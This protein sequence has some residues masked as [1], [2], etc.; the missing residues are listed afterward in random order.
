MRDLFGN[1]IKQETDEKPVKV[2]NLSPFDYLNSINMNKDNLMRDEYGINE[3]N[4]KTYNSWLVNKGLSY[5]IDTLEHS[6]NM[7]LY[8]MHLDN[9]MKY[10]YLLYSVRK[11][12]RFSKWHKAINNETID[13]IMNYY[14]ISY[15]KA[16]DFIKILTK[17]QIDQIKNEYNDGKQY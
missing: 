4:E 12:K 5:F 17:E 14:N 1:E 6:Q 8:D 13:L 7:N 2:K 16:I 11:R 10:E 3:Q 15:Y 9:L